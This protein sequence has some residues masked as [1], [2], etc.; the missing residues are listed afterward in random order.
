[1]IG[2]FARMFGS[3]ER[4]LSYEEAGTGYSLKSRAD[5]GDQ[6]AEAR[7][8]PPEMFVEKVP[9]EGGDVYVAPLVEALRRVFRRRRE[10]GEEASGDATVPALPE[11]DQTHTGSR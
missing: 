7:D 5:E 11:K 1:M 4:L 8:A 3:R 6:T 10:E 2:A 9:D